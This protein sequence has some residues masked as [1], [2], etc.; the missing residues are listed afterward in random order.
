MEAS[1]A[2]AIGLLGC[3]R[4][5][6]GGCLSFSCAGF[7][8]RDSANGDALDR[9]RCSPARKS[10]DLRCGMGASRPSF[11]V[12]RIET[13]VASRR[14]PDVDVEPRLPAV[15]PVPAR[16]G[17]LNDARN[18]GFNQI[19]LLNEIRRSLSNEIEVHLP[20]SVAFFD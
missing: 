7:C 14:P 11:D 3:D 8:V 10:T 5:E 17:L 18:I 9:R 16:S 15:Y 13:D 4:L 2:W 20:T 1:N 12:C 6:R 19:V